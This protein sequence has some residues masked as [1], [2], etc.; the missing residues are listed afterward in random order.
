MLCGSVRSDC[1]KWGKW[2][3]DMNM[4]CEGSL[5][6][7][8]T[9]SYTKNTFTW[10]AASRQYYCSSGKIK[11]QKQAKQDKTKKNAK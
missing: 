11:I 6:V 1:T 9:A 10:Q 5:V 4:I 2:S 7:E 8:K 3:K